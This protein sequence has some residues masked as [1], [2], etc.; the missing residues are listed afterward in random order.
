MKNLLKIVKKTEKNIV[1]E[2]DIDFHTEPII[3]EEELFIPAL[4]SGKIIKI[5]INDDNISTK[6]ISL[7]T[8]QK[9]IKHSLHLDKD[10]FVVNY[11]ENGS[12][13]EILIVYVTYL[14]TINKISNIK[15]N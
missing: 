3:I 13:P 9:L 7:K 12:I 5:I 6:L 2:E 11:K 8:Y 15:F 1:N 10:L 14:I 4:E